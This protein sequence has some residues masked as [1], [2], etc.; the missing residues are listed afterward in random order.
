MITAADGGL[1]RSVERPTRFCGTP[2]LSRELARS[3]GA[4]NAIKVVPTKS[5]EAQAKLGA[6][7]P[8]DSPA[9]RD[10]NL[11]DAS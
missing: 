8:Q 11:R 2:S 6:P 7:S 10:P 9:R 5:E 1:Q 4:F 3:G